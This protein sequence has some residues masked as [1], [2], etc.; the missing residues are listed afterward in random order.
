MGKAAYHEDSLDPVA[1]P[2]SLEK[3]TGALLF[4]AGI[5]KIKAGFSK[6]GQPGLCRRVAKQP[7]ADLGVHVR[8][9]VGHG[10]GQALA[11]QVIRKCN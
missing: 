5:A 6:L 1:S 7:G 11:V 4:P 8:R 3:E 2:D 10:A 9:H